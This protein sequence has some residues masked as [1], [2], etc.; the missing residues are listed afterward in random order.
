MKLCGGNNKS[1]HGCA[2]WNQST[3]WACNERNK[4]GFS[5]F[6]G[7]LYITGCSA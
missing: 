1:G 7:I 4:V 6:A 3:Y 5:S 2:Q